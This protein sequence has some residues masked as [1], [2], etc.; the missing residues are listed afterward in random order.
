MNEEI[1]IILVRYFCGEISEKENQILDGWLAQSDEN[2]KEFQRMSLLYQN[3]GQTIEIPVFNTD[4]AFS[5]FKNHINKS[6][7]PQTHLRISYI[8][9]AAAAIVVLLISCFALFYFMP[10]SS[11]TKKISSSKTPVEYEIFENTNVTLFANSE[12]IYTSKNENRIILVGKALFNVDSKISVAEIIVQ[13]G[14]TFIKDIGTIFTV[15][16][17]QP[18]KSVT[19]EVTEGEVWF[20]TNTNEGVYIKQNESAV[21]N[22]KT[23]QFR[24]YIGTQNIA[25]Q[26]DTKKQDMV[27]FNTPLGEVI[28][29]LKI[30]YG[31]DIV[32]KTNGNNSLFLN[33]SFDADDS[34]ENV[35]DI[36][37]ATFGA[38]LL[39][40]TGAYVIE[41]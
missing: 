6:E 31:V 33:A 10:N 24:M 29:M 14:E 8:W 12:I 5:K 39:K 7:K 34:I 26:I 16:A 1:D 36:I 3:I 17:T 15:D 27:F 4:N 41:F 32:V 23:K 38:Q 40:K 13:A 37:A 2:E 21:Y 18:D 19:V 9:R 28:E 20:Y 11:Q 35:M 25:P 30:S 22:V